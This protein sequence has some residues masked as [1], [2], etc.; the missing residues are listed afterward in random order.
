MPARVTEK[1]ST[2]KVL[3]FVVNL[4]KAIS[5]TNTLTNYNKIAAKGKS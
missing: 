5:L 2:L 3:N 1:I 4:F